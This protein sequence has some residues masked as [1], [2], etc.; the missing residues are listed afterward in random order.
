MRDEFFAEFVPALGVAH[1]RLVPVVSGGDQAIRD[2]KDHQ[3]SLRPGTAIVDK[4]AFEEGGDGTEA[5][6]LRHLP[7]RPRTLWAR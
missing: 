2:I 1:Q 6:E 5:V 3:V 4:E 7:R